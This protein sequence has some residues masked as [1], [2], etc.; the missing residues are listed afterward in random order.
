MKKKKIF[1]YDQC[2]ELFK[3]KRKL[4]KHTKKYIFKCDQYEQ[5]FVIP[6]KNKRSH[7]VTG[8]ELLKS[9]QKLENYM[10]K[11]HIKVCP[12]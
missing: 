12:V 10:N 11:E 1:K 4:G 5:L 8:V 9:K 3:F 6:A 2:E 7:E